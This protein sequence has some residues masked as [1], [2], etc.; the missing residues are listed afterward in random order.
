MLCSLHWLVSHPAL[1]VDLLKAYTSTCPLT[2]LFA[3]VT[4][5][6]LPAGSPGP[7]NARSSSDLLQNILPL[8]LPMLRLLSPKAQGCKIFENH[9]NPV[10]LVFIGKLSL[11]ALRWVP[12]CQGFGHFPGFF[13]HNFVIATSSIRVIPYAAL[14]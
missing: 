11:R 10:I 7:G 3:W 4:A 8:T 9:L 12:I 1:V 6:A 2:E 13:L 14:G 5:L